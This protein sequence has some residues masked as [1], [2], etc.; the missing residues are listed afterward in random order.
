MGDRSDSRQDR[1]RQHGC[2]SSHRRFALS[3]AHRTERSRNDA[4]QR[5]YLDAELYQR[6]AP[7]F[8]DG[9]I[10]ELGMTMA[11]LSGMAKFLFCFD[12]AKREESC[13]IRRGA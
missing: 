4:R 6:L 10:F 5:G 13:P 9:E 1:S 3:T 8:S 2:G 7:H 11:V 12:L